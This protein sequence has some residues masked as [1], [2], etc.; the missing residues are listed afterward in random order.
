MY[1]VKKIIREHE[2]LMNLL[3]FIYRFFGC[4]RIHGRNGLELQWMGTFCKHMNIKNNG[5]NNTVIIEKGCRF[6]NCSIEIYGN[7]NK[8][9]IGNDCAGHE[10][11]FWAS[12]G[13]K[14]EIGQHTHFAG[15]IHLAATEG[16]T[17]AVG[18]RCLF[19]SEIVVRT[20]DSHSVLDLEGN[21]VNYAKDV[22]IGN[23]VW[24]GQRAMILKGTTISDDCI[25]GANTLL[26]GGDYENNCAIAGNPAK[27]LKKNVTWCPELV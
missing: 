1:R 26:S 24:V 15:R 18:E 8:I 3:S 5:N 25:V 17:I 23:H 13:S 19:S 16:K 6:Y 9:F 11:E 12:E 4:N 2:K 10:F 21:R 22:K 27:I 14:I 20:G 7:N